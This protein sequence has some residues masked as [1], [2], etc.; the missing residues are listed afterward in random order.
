MDW[1]PRLP[2]RLSSGR[3]GVTGQEPEN[4]RE[5]GH[6]VEPGQLREQGQ[7]REQEQGLEGGAMKLASDKPAKDAERR[8]RPGRDPEQSPAV[9]WGGRDGEP[10][11]E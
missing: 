6:R 1:L 8:L 7:S 3:F 10:G 11:Q 5:T 9:C 2:L 4:C